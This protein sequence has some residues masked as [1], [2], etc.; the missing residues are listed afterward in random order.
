M[1]D[2]NELVSVIIPALNAAPTLHETL[3]SARSQS[4]AALEIIVVDDG[5]TDDTAAI[6]EAHARADR[7][8]RVI[9]QANKGLPASR[10]V[11]IASSHGAYIAPLDADDLWRRDKIELQREAL[12]R[13]GA[14]LAYCWSAIIDLDSRIVHLD[15]RSEDEGDVVTALCR[16][17]IVANGSAALVTRAAVEEVGGYD[18]R[19]ELHGCEDYMFYFQIAERHP[20]VLVRDFLVGYRERPDGM[21]ADFERMLTSHALCER[22]CAERHPERK[23][24]FRANRTRLMRFMASRCY[25]SRDLRHAGVLVARMLREDPAGTL[26]N[27]ADVALRQVGRALGARGRG[28]ELIGTRFPVGTPRGGSF[29]VA[30]QPVR[31]AA[32]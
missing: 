6:A 18:V 26:S 10:N 32:D 11:A 30:P 25:R 15:S 14:A 16:R 23:A 20:F 17:N 2:A 7:R 1:V 31:F 8:V 29:P 9:R 21:S 24:L 3:L 12:R 22:E 19:D 13:T 27:A 5:S 4:H 28:Q